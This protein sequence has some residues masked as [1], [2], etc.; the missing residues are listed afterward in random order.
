MGSPLGLQD[1]PVDMAGR[2]WHNTLSFYLF[3]YVNVQVEL[4]HSSHRH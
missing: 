3:S 2:S 1:P 4:P